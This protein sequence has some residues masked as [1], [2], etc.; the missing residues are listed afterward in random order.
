[1]T[2]LSSNRTLRRGRV[3]PEIQLSPEDKARRKAEWEE[4]NQRCQAIFERLQPELIIEHYNWFMFIEPDSGNYFIAQDE[5]VVRQEAH[6]QYP[7][8]TCL[9]LR[10]NETG[11][12]GKI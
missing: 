3:F 12:C 9:I 11:V 1:M 8:K 6:K 7:E 5:M 4:F 10:I 2:Q